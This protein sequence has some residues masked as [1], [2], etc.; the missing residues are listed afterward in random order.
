MTNSR[1][2]G[3]GKNLL[4]AIR[5][6]GESGLVIPVGTSV[7]A[8]LRPIPTLSTAV[9][10]EDVRVLTEWRNRHVN[11][12]LSIFNATPERTRAWLAGPVHQ[13]DGKMLFMVESLDG[14][15]LGQIGLGFIDWS[16]GYG[17][18]DAIISGGASPRGLMRESLQTLMSWARRSLGLRDLWVRVRSDNPAV[19]F[20][21]KTGF[22]ERKRVPISERVISQE[23]R[24]WSESPSLRDTEPSLVHMEYMR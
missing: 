6:A 4:M 22:F 18:A 9:V 20:Y 5:D 13:N 8:I 11:S 21:R 3:S 23:E 19:E 2:P 10:E 1:V 16:R 14:Q 12:F 7:H 15:R 24:V 17:E